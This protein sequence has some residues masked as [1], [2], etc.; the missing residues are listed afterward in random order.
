MTTYIV[1]HYKNCKGNKKHSNDWLVEDLLRS[2]RP[3][4]CKYFED[5]E[6]KAFLNLA[7]PSIRPHMAEMQ[8]TRWSKKQQKII[9]LEEEEAE[10]EEK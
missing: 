8:G 10:D 3:P 1:H 2:K 7:E 4:T 9:Y 5:S 6:V